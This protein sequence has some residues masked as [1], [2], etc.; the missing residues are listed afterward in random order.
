MNMWSLF[1]EDNDGFLVPP[2]PV[3]SASQQPAAE[4]GAEPTQQPITEVL[5]NPTKVLLLKVDDSIDF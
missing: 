5:K 1:V 3:S 4:P 2:A